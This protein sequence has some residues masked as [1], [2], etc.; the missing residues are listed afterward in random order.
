[1][2][3]TEGIRRLLVDV[4]NVAPDE[5]AELELEHGQ[6]WDTEQLQDDF[7]VE[8]FLAPFIG[9]TRKVDNK[10]GL[11]MFQHNPRYYFNFK[12]E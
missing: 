7:R 10:K 2:D 12:E 1:M 8:G 3:K 11:M 9:V 6:V 5:R 4:I